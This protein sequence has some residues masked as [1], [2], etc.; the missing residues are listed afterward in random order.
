MIGVVNS[1]VALDE[2]RY[3]YCN[4]LGIDSNSWGY[5]YHG[6]VQYNQSK[7]KY[8]S[9][10]GLGTLIGVHLDMY[11]GTLE[12]YLNRQPLGESSESFFINPQH[13]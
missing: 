9:R 1:E 2:K 7:V 6:Y 11:R 13:R 5:S 8:G 12:Y 4:I 10:Y 3:K